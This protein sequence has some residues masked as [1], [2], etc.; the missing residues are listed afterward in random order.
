MNVANPVGEFSFSVELKVI[1][2]HVIDETV[3][4]KTKKR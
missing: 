4:L 2:M 3:E 1:I